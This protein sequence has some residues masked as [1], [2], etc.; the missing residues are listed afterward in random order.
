M[1]SFTFL[2]G[3]RV[4]CVCVYMCICMCMRVLCKRAHTYT[5]VCVHG[6]GLYDDCREYFVLVL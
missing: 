5:R 2:L 4:M 3:V 6:D 1:Y